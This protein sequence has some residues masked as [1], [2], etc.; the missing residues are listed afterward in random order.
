MEWTELKEI[1]KKNMEEMTYN[2]KID[3]KFK[4]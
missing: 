1:K 4:S 2:K 3:S